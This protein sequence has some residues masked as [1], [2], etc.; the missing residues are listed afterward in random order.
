VIEKLKKG[1]KIDDLAK[2]SK[3]PGSKDRGG[4]LG[5]ANP[6]SFVP[7]FSA[8]MTKLEKG[9]FTEAPV[10]TDFGWH[11]ILLEDTR[12]LKLPGVDEAKGQIGQQLTQRTGA[13]AH[14]RVARQSQSGVSS[15]ARVS[16]PPRIQHSRHPNIFRRET[17]MKLRPF[18]T[19]ALIAFTAVPLVSSAQQKA[20][21]RQGTQA[22]LNALPP[23]LRAAL[24]TG[25]ATAIEQAIKRLGGR[26]RRASRNPGRAGRTS[27][28][29]SLPRPTQPPLPPAL[30]RR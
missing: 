12:E 20:P 16:V 9:K 18:L 19:A 5:W 23:A 17:T 1:E 10:K 25:N 27:R 3:D 13:K 29:L 4:D 2:E 26:Q 15:R 21:V 28:Q 14:R 11:V 30:R 6:A 24:L 8:A 22:D 7:P